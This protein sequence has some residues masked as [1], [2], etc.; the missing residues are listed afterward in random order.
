MHKQRCVFLLE[1]FIEVS[2][3]EFKPLEE[4]ELQT[5]E[6]GSPD[7]VQNVEREPED[8]WEEAPT[9]LVL[10]EEEDTKSQTGDGELKEMGGSSSP[11]VNE[12]EQFDAV[13]PVGAFSE[14]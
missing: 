5:E 13:S 7:D 8:N 6:K 12:W 10:I 3:D 14:N 9:P 4:F 2:E 1:S 11:A